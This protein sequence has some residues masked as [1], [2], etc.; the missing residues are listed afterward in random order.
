[1]RWSVRTIVALLSG[2]IPSL[3]VADG[4]F[5]GPYGLSVWEPSQ[6]ALIVYDAADRIEQ[7]IIQPGFRSQ[8]SEFAWIVPVPGLPEIEAACGDLF[9]ECYLLTEPIE[10]DRGD[11]FACADEQVMYDVAPPTIENGGVIIHAEEMIGIYETITVSADDAAQL[12]D[13]LY[14]W[15]YLHEENEDEVLAALSHYIEQESS[16]YFVALRVKSSDGVYGEYWYGGLEPVSFTFESDEIIYPMRISKI[17][18][19]ASTSLVLYICADH[20]L[21]CPGAYTDYANRISG[22]E[23]SAIRA[24]YPCLGDL[25][26]NGCF[27]TKL[28]KSL[29]VGEMDDDIFFT[30]AGADEEFRQIRYTGLPFPE[31]ILLVLAG[32]VRLRFRRRR[33][34]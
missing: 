6:S 11:G 28:R 23:L 8:A 25:L 34:S 1:M 27:L 4:G 30:P 2:L 17:S 31:L 18:T 19:Q 32:A 15:G 10:R 7:L 5:V 21:V 16:W 33:R 14:A 3:A 22:P 26:P 13:S 20:R 9:Q 29:S 24:E 12:A